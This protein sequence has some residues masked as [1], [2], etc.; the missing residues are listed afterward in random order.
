MEERFFNIFKDEYSYNNC[1][2]S[3]LKLF[4]DAKDNGEIIDYCVNLDDD[5]FDSPGLDIY[6][7]SV[8]YVDN[9]SKVH[10]IGSP[11]YRE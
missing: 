2:D 3:V 1:R 8:G 9:K 7:I 11:Y 6:Y 5:V 4:G 10:C